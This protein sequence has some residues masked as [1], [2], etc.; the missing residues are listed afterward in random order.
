MD[1]TLTFKEIIDAVSK[2]VSRPEREP[3]EDFGGFYAPETHEAA[4]VNRLS[5]KYAY[6]LAIPLYL[7]LNMP[8]ECQFHTTSGMFSKEF[9]S[10]LLYER[11]LWLRN[12]HSE[13]KRYFKIALAEIDSFRIRSLS[14]QRKKYYAIMMRVSDL[15]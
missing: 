10:L 7:N 2:F 9:T 8:A 13:D 15:L 3:G 14:P 1:S 12:I 6:N 5:F 4:D 11:E